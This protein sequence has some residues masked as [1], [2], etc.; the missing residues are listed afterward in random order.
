MCNLTAAVGQGML[1]VLEIKDGRPRQLIHACVNPPEHGKHSR[2]L[3]CDTFL[4]LIVKRSVE[5]VQVEI[6]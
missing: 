4:R 2:R 1:S 3:M 5:T 6:Q